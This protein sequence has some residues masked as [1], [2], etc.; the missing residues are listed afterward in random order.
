MS[1]PDAL[2]LFLGIPL[3]TSLTQALGTWQ[4]QQPTASTLRWV[5]PELWHITI[6]FFGQVPEERKEN[7]IALL[8]VGLKQTPTFTLD[9]D[10][11]VLAPKPHE[12]RMIWARYQKHEAF[13][14]LVVR[15]H[16]LYQQIDPHIQM[17]KSPIPHI[18]LA[19]L[20][21]PD[22]AQEVSLDLPQDLA[23]EVNHCVLWNSTLTP[24]GPIYTEIASFS[25]KK[26]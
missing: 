19:R 2:R 9:F 18:T 12:P 22:A 15:L 10:R 1:S 5:A 16:R 17:R 21:T 23:M 4:A 11:L 25:L 13:R 6:Y 7:L 20:K 24:S 26:A 3:P 14:Q 8:E